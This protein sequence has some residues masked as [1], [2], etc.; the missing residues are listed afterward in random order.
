MMALSPGSQGTTIRVPPRC[1]IKFSQ[2]F[3]VT[4]FAVN[5]EDAGTGG[6]AS[7]A[8]PDSP[9]SAPQ[10]SA[11]PRV[12]SGVSTLAIGQRVLPS[13]AQTHSASAVAAPLSYEGLSEAEVMFRVKAGDDAAFNYLAER[14]RRPKIGRAHV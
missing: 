11:N 13:S 2:A 1:C 10:L 3:G 4:K 14:Y 8:R 7:A 5:P 6:A 12:S 9:S